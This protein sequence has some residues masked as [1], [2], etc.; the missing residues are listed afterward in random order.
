MTRSHTAYARF[1]KRTLDAVIAG[2]A[3]FLLLPVF[4]LVAAAV[5]IKLGTPVFFFQ[6]R[7]GWQRRPFRIIKFRTMLDICNAD[8]QPLPDEV[9][10][11]PFGN[12]LRKTSLD[13]L[14]GLLN[15]LRGEMSF[16]GPRP[17]M[18]RYDPLYSPLQ[19]R[20]FEVRPGITGWAQVN[21]RNAL[22]W[23]EKFDLDTWYVDNWSLGLDLKILAATL[24]AVARGEGIAGE[25]MATMSE[26]KG[27]H[28][29]TD[30]RRSQSD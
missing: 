13:E 3:L 29:I 23:E 5:A 1:G 14:P 10:L 15:V 28:E 8:G 17:L 16:V 22:S 18:H 7:T 12:W 21:G 26:F 25:G 2:T 27:S 6:E 4:G 24:R 20:R 19:A 9:R 30:A 11:T